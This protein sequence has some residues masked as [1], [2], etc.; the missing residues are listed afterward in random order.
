MRELCP[1]LKKSVAREHSPTFMAR[2]RTF[3]L[4][5]WLSVL[6]A[7]AA[8]A[9]D[10]IVLLTAENTARQPRFLDTLRIQ[11]AGLAKV[12]D[13]GRLQTRS[14]SERI[15]QALGAAEQ[16]EALAAIWVE[17]P[18]PRNDGSAELLLYVV[19][20]REDRALVDVLRVPT[21]SGNINGDN[22]SPASSIDA[23]VMRS[24]ALK[25]RQVLLDL[26]YATDAMALSATTNTSQASASAQLHGLLLAGVI[27][28]TASGSWPAQMGL[29]VGVGVRVET[30]SLRLDLLARAHLTPASNVTS[31]K[32][33]IDLQEYAPAL[34]AILG[35]FA[36]SRVELGVRAA[37][38]LDVLDASGQTS[39]GARGSSTSLVPVMVVGP[40]L[41]VSLSRA[42]ELWLGIDT[43]WSLVRQR[44]A[45]NNDILADRAYLRGT[46][47]LGLVLLSP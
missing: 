25:V 10:T 18:M 3:F 29:R 47:H 21:R 30:R 42:V 13:G 45:F 2:R 1:R 26:A 38:G 31:K 44:Y 12:V 36:N 11:L 16:H 15:D 32:G 20:R 35:M 19:G 39:S 41:G 6:L 24:L 33:S 28:R 17:G 4:V 37:L 23:S 9:Q 7:N 34:E 43:E 14:H 40:Q 8:T 27:A 22:A 46:L 5:L